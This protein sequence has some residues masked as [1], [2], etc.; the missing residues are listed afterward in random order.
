M[1]WVVLCMEHGLLSGV[2]S[3]LPLKRGRCNNWGPESRVL[4]HAQMS[5][6][7]RLS[8]EII[9]FLTVCGVQ[10]L[11]MKTD[12]Y[13]YS[14]AQ[15]LGWCEDWDTCCPRKDQFN[16]YFLIARLLNSIASIV[17]ATPIQ[18]FIMT[19]FGLHLSMASGFATSMSTFASAFAPFFDLMETKAAKSMIPRH[20][21]RAKELFIH[22]LR[23]KEWQHW[24]SHPVTRT[25]RLFVSAWAWCVHGDCRTVSWAMLT[26]LLQLFYLC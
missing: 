16:L 3:L 21:K 11:F 15:C 4:L 17:L 23:V 13:E 10:A 26:F 1:F 8:M 5:T 7:E 14:D 19:L 9:E 22:A 20:P 2:L 24:I 25:M 18:V 12:N 6:A